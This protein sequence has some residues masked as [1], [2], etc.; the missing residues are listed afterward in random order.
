MPGRVAVYG[1]SSC[2]DTAHSSRSISQCWWLLRELVDFAAKGALRPEF[3]P[4]DSRLATKYVDASMP[5]A[6]QR[7]EGNKL[8]EYSNVL[9]HKLGE[10]CERADPFRAAAAVH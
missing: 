9:G 5:A 3:F 8:A 6:P 7:V 1:D 2:I 4:P 10:S